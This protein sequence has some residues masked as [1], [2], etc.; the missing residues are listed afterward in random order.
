MLCW[1]HPSEPGFEPPAR[2]SLVLSLTWALPCS[3]RAQGHLSHGEHSLCTPGWAAEVLS[4]WRASESIDGFLS[5]PSLFSLLFSQSQCELQDSL[6][7]FLRYVRTGKKLQKDF[8]FK[9]IPSPFPPPPPPR[10]LLPSLPCL[11]WTAVH[12][13]QCSFLPKSQPRSLPDKGQQE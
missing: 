4:F 1:N 8:Y 11:L 10:Y 9:V 13:L 12:A 2:A 3:R 5:F 6:Q 7:V